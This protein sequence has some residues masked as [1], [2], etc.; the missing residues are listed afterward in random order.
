MFRQTFKLTLSKS[1][2]LIDL[3]AMHN[4][5]CVLSKGLGELCGV[6]PRDESK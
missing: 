4:Q 3:V 2:A 6:V 1:L 5:I